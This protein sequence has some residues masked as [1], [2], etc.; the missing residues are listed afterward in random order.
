LLWFI[1]LGKLFGVSQPALV[2]YYI[3]DGYPNQAV[4]WLAQNRSRERLL[5]EYNWGGYL[6]WSLRGF[7][8]F[9]DGRTDLF[10]DEIVGQWIT[11]VQGGEGWQEILD[12]YQVDLVMLQPDRPLLVDLAQ[13]G[14]QPLYRDSQAVIYGRK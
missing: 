14:W 9:V 2:N 5:S 1:V 10:N 3:K 12:R 11:A 8:I 6:Q 4:E 13:A 7:P